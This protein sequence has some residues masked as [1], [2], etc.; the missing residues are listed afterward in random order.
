MLAAHREVADLIQVGAYVAGSD[1]RVEAACAAMPQI[2][3]FLKQRVSEATNIAE[4]RKRMQL[5]A[6]LRD[7]GR[8]PGR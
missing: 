3:A 1:P 4:T 7:R 8:Q 2:D 5:L 6:A